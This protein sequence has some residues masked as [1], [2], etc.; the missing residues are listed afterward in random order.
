MRRP[1]RTSEAA[2]AP[3]SLQAALVVAKGPACQNQEAFPEL[4][5]DV[6]GDFS[7]ESK[8]LRLKVEARP[9]ENMRCRDMLYHNCGVIR[10]VVKI[11]VPFG[12]LFLYGT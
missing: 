7:H 4:Y 3:E 1:K 8:K 6:G 9:A 12:S 10:V 2:D 5:S 11:M